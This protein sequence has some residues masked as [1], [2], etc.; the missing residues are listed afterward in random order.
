MDLSKTTW[1]ETPDVGLQGADKASAMQRLWYLWPSRYFHQ[2]M[3]FDRHSHRTC[4]L[5]EGYMQ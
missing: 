4:W 2:Y 1:I 5:P 3:F